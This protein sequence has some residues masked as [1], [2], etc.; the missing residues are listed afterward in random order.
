MSTITKKQLLLAE[1]NRARAEVNRLRADLG[2]PPSAAASSTDAPALSPA[3]SAA[4]ATMSIDAP[5]QTTQMP[6][7][8]SVNAS[9]G[10]YY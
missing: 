9:T 10:R 8:G 4:T 1:L 5:Q 2:Y 3:L 6:P 7:R